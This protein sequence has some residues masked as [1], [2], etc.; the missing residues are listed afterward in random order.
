MFTRTAH[1]PECAICGKSRSQHHERYGYAYCYPKIDTLST[2]VK[3]A[4]MYRLI[5]SY[6]S[7]PAHVAHAM[8]IRA[9][10]CMRAARTIKNNLHT[11]R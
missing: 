3:N 2:L 1:S 9:V 8:R 7:T 11:I 5:A 6:S 4:R 10:E